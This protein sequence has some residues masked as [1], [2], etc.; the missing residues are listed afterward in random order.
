MPTIGWFKILLIKAF[1]FKLTLNLQYLSVEQCYRKWIDTIIKVS[2][3]Y[4]NTHDNDIHVLESYLIVKFA[5]E[6]LFSR[7]RSSI[8]CWLFLM[9]SKYY[10]DLN[11]IFKINS[12]LK[13]LVRKKSGKIYTF[14]INL[15]Q[16]CQFS[17]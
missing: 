1:Y 5:Y 11:I 7:T 8:N 14:Q 6:N 3:H 4:F 10:W 17:L 12:H 9:I 15:F 2:D 13:L 16:F